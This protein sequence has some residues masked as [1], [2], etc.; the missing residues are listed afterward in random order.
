MITIIPLKLYID[1][2]FTSFECRHL[3][4]FGAVS[5]DGNHEFYQEVTDY[6]DDTCSPF[7]IKHV[8]NLLDH[9]RYGMTYDQVARTLST[10]IDSI[11]VPDIEV[12]VDYSGDIELMQELLQNFPT[13]TNMIYS[14]IE[15]AFERTLRE[16]GY[17]LDSTIISAYNEALLGMKQYFEIDPRQHHALVDAKSNRHGWITGVSSAFQL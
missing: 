3:L 7:V 14:Y 6:P 15:P 5:E 4:S 13:R 16:L 2:E 9:A 1:T 10:W 12:I 11:G 8:L 17:T